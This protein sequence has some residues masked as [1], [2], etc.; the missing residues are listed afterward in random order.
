MGLRDEP[1]LGGLVID[2]PI[3]AARQR[4]DDL[5]ALYFDVE[6][7]VGHPLILAQTGPLSAAPSGSGF[8]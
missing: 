8:C 1:R 7:V 6:V 4:D 2:D 5:A 3:V